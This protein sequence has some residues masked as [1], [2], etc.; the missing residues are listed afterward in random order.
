MS[1]DLFLVDAVGLLRHESA[2]EAHLV[3]ALTD[4]FDGP[5][6][7]IESLG[8]LVVGPGGATGG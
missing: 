4:A 2:G 5:D 1:L 8:G 7:D 3:K 6:V